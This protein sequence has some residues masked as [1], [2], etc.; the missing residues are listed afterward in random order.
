MA[1]LQ[2]Q[3]RNMWLELREPIYNIVKHPDLGLDPKRYMTIYTHVYNHCTTKTT[4]HSNNSA[5][6]QGKELYDNL[7]QLL[8]GFMQELLDQANTKLDIDLLIFYMTQWTK[9]T[10]A[11]KFLDHLFHYLN[12]H[13]VKRRIDD[14]QEGVYRIHTMCLVTWKAHLFQTISATL[15]KAV[16]KQIETERDGESVDRSM[17]KQIL[18][19]Y[20]ALD[21]PATDAAPGVPNDPSMLRDSNVYREVFENQFFDETRVYYKAES[22]KFLA[23]NSVTEYMKKAEKRL[24]EEVERVKMYL[25]ESTLAS[26]LTLC[27]GHLIFDHEDT[28]KEEFG[29]L[30]AT[31]RNEDMERMYKLVARK[32]DRL[33]TLRTKLEIHV[34]Q[35]G[36]EAV[37]A[38]LAGGSANGAAA[39]GAG[40][41]DDE[42]DGGA[43]AGAGSGV[44]EPKVYVDALLSVHAKYHKLVETAFQGDP[45]FAQSL[46]KACREFINRNAVCE[47]NPKRS[48]E[49][50]ARYCDVLLRKSAKNPEEA[51]LEA[52]LTS[53]MTVFKY[54]DDK[55]V[56]QRYYSTALSG[57]LVR[58]TSASMDAEETMINKLKEACGFEYTQKLQRMFTDMGLSKDINSDFQKKMAASATGAS[59][60]LV[61]FYVMVLTDVAWPFG[62]QPTEFRLPQELERTFQKF[63]DFYQSKH[64]G[65]K[66]TWQFNHSRGE[67]KAVFPKSKV[68][69]QLS[70]HMYQMGI[71]LQ[72]NS[73]D[74]YTL[75]ELLDSTG[76]NLEY[77]KGHLSTL[78]KA[79]ILLCEPAGKQPGEP[80]TRYVFNAD[81]KNKKTRLNLNVK[82]KAE[83][84]SET[85]DTN[86]HIEE[87]RKLLIQAAIVRV[88]K[89][90][91]ALKHPLLIQEVIDQLKS[92]FKPNV[93]DIKKMIDLLIEKEYIERVEGE[94]DTYS[95]IA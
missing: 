65:R 78:C 76:L 9:F 62:Q 54:I 19:S 12:R 61:D 36:L 5:S 21:L 72:Y 63:T 41:D 59:D 92:R 94:K 14:N 57:R 35:V 55:D 45:G 1:H 7:Q 73:G 90:R 93:S 75:Q 23:E 8:Q 71:L 2:S 69:Y 95:Y 27:E 83:E 37:A 82:I 49:L 10:E 22:A 51:E 31:D 32:P 26:L 3:Q 88:M 34:R 38:V 84:K 16:L 53:I 74:V 48:P 46:D 20:V 39:A 60:D 66:L 11:S 6:V 85:D 28:L 77:L 29:N 18:G 25:H 80:N 33:D 67:V 52:L 56:F 17:L 91:K 70:V 44:L 81:Y 43:A 24:D 87:D 42:A 4:T 58:G 86:K 50:L 13:W 40:G 15:T 79:K 30:L 68:P 89:T 64:S 47:K